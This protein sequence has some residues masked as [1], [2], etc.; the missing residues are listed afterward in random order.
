MTA[1][2]TPPARLPLWQRLFFAIPVL[3][4]VARD[5]AFGDKHNIWYAITGFVSLWLSSAL[6]FGVPGFYIPALALAP[7]IFITL[8][9]IT[10]G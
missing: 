6:I 9:F 4:W 8:I 7:I 3:G 2:A 1:T 10:W 5:L